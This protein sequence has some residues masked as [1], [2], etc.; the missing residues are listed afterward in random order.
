M[1]PALCI[2]ALSF[3]IAYAAFTKTDKYNKYV[4]LAKVENAIASVLQQCEKI[5]F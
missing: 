1:E 5:A 4:K 2:G 3:P